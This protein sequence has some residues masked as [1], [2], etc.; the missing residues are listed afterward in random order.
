MTAMKGGDR[1]FTPAFFANA[2]VNLMLYVN[3]YVLMVVMAG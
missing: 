3:Y 1:I 2:F